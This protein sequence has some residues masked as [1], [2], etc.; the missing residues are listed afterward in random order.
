M[1]RQIMVRPKETRTRWCAETNNG[2]TEKT[3]N[4][5]VAEPNNGAAER[6]KNKVECRDK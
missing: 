3:K 1:Q 2:A 4:K 6:I 5:V